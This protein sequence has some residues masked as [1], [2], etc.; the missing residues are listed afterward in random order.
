ML[1]GSVIALVDALY[2]VGVPVMETVATVPLVR[3]AV[4]ALSPGGKF[5]MLKLAAVIVAA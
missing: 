2:V 4:V 3:T 5:E 1:V